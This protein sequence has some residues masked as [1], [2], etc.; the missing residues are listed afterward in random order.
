MNVKHLSVIAAVFACVVAVAIPARAQSTAEDLKREIEGLKADYEARIKALEERLAAVERD[1]ATTKREVS[2]IQPTVEKAVKDAVDAVE[3]GAN[4][5]SDAARKIATTPRYNELQDVELALGKLER[6]AKAFEFHGYVRSG[7]GGNGRG[8]QQ[9]AFKAPGAGAKYRLGNEAETYGELIFVNNWLNPSHAADKAWIKTEL[10]V[11]ADTDNSSTYS[12]TD[13]FR[14]REA[15]VQ[16]GNLFESQPTLK[17]WAGERYYRR[18][19]IHVNDFFIL[20]MSGYGGGFEDLNVGV[21]RVA[22]AYLA[23]ASADVVT[24]SGVFTKQTLDARLYDV[25][26]PGGL[27]GVWYNLAYAKGG[28][29]GD[30]QVIPTRVGHAVGFAHTATELF[31]GYNRFTAMYG[32]GPASTFTTGLEI[33]EPGAKES[34]HLLITNHT[35]VEPNER[36]A[37]MPLF[38]YDRRT[39]G[40]AG[41]GVDT[42]VSFGA[43]PLLKLTDH[44]SLAIEG[45]FDYTKSDRGVYEGWL[46]KITVA[47]QIGAA[48]GF[49]SRPVLRLFVT[50]ANWS[51]GFRGLVGGVP[52]A[53]ATNG[54]T[55]GVQAEHWW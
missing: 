48:R 2:T 33:P 44:F 7:F 1:Q 52:Y 18:Q 28:T 35:L 10:L 41:D 25:K 49:F 54:F 26:V 4:S 39:G 13:R 36:W 47:P 51:G 34:A 30:G 17:L 53:N 12:S 43:R 20:D 27:L 16:A 42:W 6:Q 3:N 37:V 29:T 19:D 46:R 23:G 22:V 32:R 9:V 50:Y 8:G 40:S 55:F 38:V 24:E 45:G 15:F 5:S 14:L 31:G 21:G 11:Q